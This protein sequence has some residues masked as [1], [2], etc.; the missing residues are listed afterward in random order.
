[1]AEPPRL[2]LFDLDG[3]LAAYDRDARCRHLAQTVGAGA[4]E[5]HA[6]L[7]GPNGLEPRS[8]AGELDLPGYL[9]QLRAR[10]GWRLPQDDFLAARRH[11]TQVDPAMLRLCAALAPQARLAI[12]TNNGAWLAEYAARIVPELAPLFGEDLVCSGSLRRLKPEPET[13]RDCLRRL[14]MSPEATLFVDDRA[15]NV[16]GAR[17]A[18]L[19]AV[20]HVD[21]AGLRVALIERGFNPGANHAT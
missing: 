6:A 1:M 21:V 15:E 10:H 13:Y 7:F 8:D 3:V 2:L 19:D 20:L 4:D 16:E 9:G 11:A 18:G 5:V 12:L 14:G 17:A